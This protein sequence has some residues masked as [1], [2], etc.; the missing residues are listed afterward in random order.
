MQNNIPQD[1]NN[2]VYSF[3]RGAFAVMTKLVYRARYHN[4]ERLKTIQ[5]PCIL[6]GNH[7]TW[8]DPVLLAVPARHQ[9]YRIMGKKELTNNFI[10]KKLAPKMHMISVGRGESDMAAMRSCMRALKDERVLLIFP[11]GTRHQ[12]SLMHEVETGAAVLALRAKVPMIPVYIHGKPSLFKRVDVYV[13]APMDNADLYAE[14]P[15]METAGKLADRIRNT[16][17]AMRDEAQKEGK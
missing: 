9:Q 7:Q 12:P 14:G 17:F 2:W 8:A 3:V 4:V 6:M 11:E 15:N 13:G 1:P 16:Y 10:M 5:G